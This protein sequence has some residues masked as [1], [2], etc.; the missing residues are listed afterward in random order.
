MLVADDAS[1]LAAAV[2]HLYRDQEA[3]QE[4]SR[5]AQDFVAANFSRRN[6]RAIMAAVLNSAGIT[7]GIG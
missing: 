5:A 3:W 4:V 2:L 6:G 7:S 1:G